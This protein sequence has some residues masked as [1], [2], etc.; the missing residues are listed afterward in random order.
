MIVESNREIRIPGT[1]E[2]YERYLRENN[3]SDAE[4]ARWRDTRAAIEAQRALFD[5]LDAAR[6]AAGL[7]SFRE[8]YATG[9]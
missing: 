2:G 3:A 4:W 8:S 5:R 1:V 9:R 6:E 7:E